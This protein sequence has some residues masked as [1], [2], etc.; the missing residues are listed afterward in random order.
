MAWLCSPCWFWETF[1][2][3]P[4]RFF[5]RAKPQDDGFQGNLSWPR[6]LRSKWFAIVLLLSFFWAYEVFALWS[7]PW[8]T[9]WIAVGYFAAA[10]LVDSIFRGAS[11]CK[12]LCPIGQFHFIHSLVSPMEV[13]VRSTSICETCQ[14]KDCIRGNEQKRG[15]ELDL[16]LP[17][18][19]GN[20]DCTFCLD[21]LHA[22]PRNNV[23]I[24]LVTP[25]EEL[26]RDPQRSGIGRFSQR[27]DLSFLVLL[28]V[29]LGLANAAAMVAPTVAF[30]QT[31]AEFSR[32]PVACV[33]TIVFLSM[34]FFA[35]LAGGRRRFPVATLEP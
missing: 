31:L 18:K 16:F 5:C 7:N 33:K 12:Y 13:K 23:G 10:F 4:V 19:A 3:S 26:L 6:P 11:F 17:R 8:W 15:C 25:G 20:M 34:V 1:S 27:W 9:A 14:T 22:C 32:T 35:D 29:F 28:L 30:E 2:A 21:C 24:E